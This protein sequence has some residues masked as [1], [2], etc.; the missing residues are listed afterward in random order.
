MSA[1]PAAPRRRLGP[2]PLPAWIYFNLTAF[3]VEGCILCVVLAWPILALDRWQVSPA[4]LG[5][6]GLFSGGAYALSALAVGHS[7]RFLSPR[8]AMVIGSGGQI[9]FILLEP[10]C[11]EFSAFLTLL[12]IQM[13]LFAFF[14]PPFQKTLA[15]AYPPAALSRA[16][17][18]FNVSWCAGSMLCGLASGPLFDYVG[19]A[20]PY[21]AA[22][23]GMVLA[24]AL[25][26]FG[27]PN[28]PA[29]SVADSGLPIPA[30]SPIEARAFVRRGWLGLGVC[31]FT[32]GMLIHLF[33][34]L[35]RD[36]PF[37]LSP[38]AISALHA[39]RH[40]AMLAAFATMGATSAWHF[41]RYPLR[42]CLLLVAIGCGTLAAAGSVGWVVFAFIVLGLATGMAFAL[43]VYYSL[44]EADSRGVR[45]GVQESL[46][47]LAIALG[48]TIGGRI[49]VA[50]G[51]GRLPYWLCLAAVAAIWLAVASRDLTRSR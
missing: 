6:I 28:L 25:V 33:P 8:L 17:G 24:L 48:P 34:Y 32:V 14:W 21:Q 27:R 26:L 9:V 31:F 13:G 35:A 40:F 30:H 22:S 12:T 42:I 41:H 4:Q 43:S 47:A 15:E 16:L 29:V 3:L 5:L 50:S 7:L 45:I 39:L 23:V 19:P 37:N 1:D 38:S 49:H 20:A 51:E 46:L 2:I 11:R 36:E 10:R 18:R 44:F